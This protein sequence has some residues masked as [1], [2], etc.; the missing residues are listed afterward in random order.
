MSV[1]RNF[2]VRAKDVRAYLRSLL[3][4][5][6]KLLMP[7]RGFYR[8]AETVTVSRASAFIMMYNIVEYA[9][10]EAILEIR[11]DIANHAGNFGL[12]LDHWK[13]EI[14]DAHFYERMQQGTNHKSL[15]MDV[16]A[17]MPGKIS[18]ENNL[19]KLPFPGNVDHKELIRFV[20]KIDYSWKPPKGCLG[21]SDLELVRQMRND[22][23]H[24]L[25]TFST[26]GSQYTTQDMIDKFDRVR[27]VLL[28]FIRMVERYKARQL[29]LER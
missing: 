25:E 5:E 29:Y 10:R 11:S 18:W 8:A 1:E 27:K 6:T 15:L 14:I 20:K 9:V 4:L 2:L 7:G 23:A 21:G 12:L 19:N 3:E 24:G 13:Q 22:L 28:S 16:V 26:V 17:F